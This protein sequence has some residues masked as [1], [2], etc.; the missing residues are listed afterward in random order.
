[1]G[2]VTVRRVDPCLTLVGAEAGGMI[3]PDRE[4]LVGWPQRD[5]TPTDRRRAHGQDHASPERRVEG[6]LRL[7]TATAVA[8][9]AE[10]LEWT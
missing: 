10:R 5:Q 7:H 9:R 8:I 6:C 4:S 2:V 3:M 1:V